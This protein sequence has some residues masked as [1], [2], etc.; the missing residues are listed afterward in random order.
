VHLLLTDAA[1]PD[2]DG[3]QLIRDALASNP[4]L[5]VIVM[6]A[7]LDGLRDDANEDLQ[8]W[9]LLTKPFSPSDLLTRVRDVLDRR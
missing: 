6:S 7:A 9:N 5:S 1:L 8:R 3:S 4:Q 2:A